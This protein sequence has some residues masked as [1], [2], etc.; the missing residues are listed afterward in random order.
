MNF[1]NAVTIER[2]P[3]DVFSFL[4]HFEN[5]PTWNYAIVE[6]RALSDDP[7]AVG[8]SYRQVRSLPRSAEESFEV[9][10]FEPYRALQITGQVGPFIGAL[11]YELE[12]LG[13]ATRLTNSVHLEARGLAKIAEAIS[14]DR[15]QAAVAAN[16][17]VLKEVVE[18]SRQ[19]RTTRF[20]TLLNDQTE[21][22]TYLRPLVV[23][24]S[25][26]GARATRGA[27]LGR[28]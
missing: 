8:K 18:G 13:A 11:T 19:S 28:L 7:V 2:S 24:P 15:I 25:G 12:D 20:I 16:L 9:T 6:T 5:I 1:A 3:G 22:P 14:A 17:A 10:L 21:R 4:A 26:V 27:V 23:F